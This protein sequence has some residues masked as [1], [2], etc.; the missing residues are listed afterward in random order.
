ME[1]VSATGVL[2]S[3]LE[4]VDYGF[5]VSFKPAMEKDCVR[6]NVSTHVPKYIQHEVTIQREG[7]ENFHRII[8]SQMCESMRFYMGEAGVAEMNE[9]NSKNTINGNNCN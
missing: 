7:L 5:H 8:F 1:D 4:M 3:V 6:I 2:N 9:T